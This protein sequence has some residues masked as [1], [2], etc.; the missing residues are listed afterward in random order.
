[1]NFLAE[2]NQK[3]LKS[4]PKPTVATLQQRLQPTVTAITPTLNYEETW[5][6]YHSGAIVPLLQTT[7]IPLPPLVKVM[8]SSAARSCLSVAQWRRS[9]WGVFAGGLQQY[10]ITACRWGWE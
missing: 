2:L 8:V 1:M 5:Q 7:P 10:T 4:V 3:K 9:W 6:Q